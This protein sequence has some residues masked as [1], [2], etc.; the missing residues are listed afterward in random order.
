MSDAS[1]KPKKESLVAGSPADKRQ[2]AAKK[3]REERQKAYTRNKRQ[4]LI[5]KIVVL[6]IV[7]GALGGIGYGIYDKTKSSAEAAIPDGVKSY[8]YASGQHD[9]NFN[10]W[11]ENPPV[12]GIHNNTW[13]KCQFYSAPIMTGKGVHS[14][15]HGA[16]W[17][18]YSPDLPQD[19]IDKI[20]AVADGQ[21]FI[22]ASPYLG[23][24]APIVLSSWNHQLLLQSFDQKTVDQFIKVFKHSQ[25]YTPEYGANCATGDTSTVG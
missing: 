6:V 14:L 20:K 11:T 9:D 7:I 25:Q 21:D 13:Q 23:I 22:L 4:I 5:T 15:E 12:G 1:R 8:T 17:I 2:D 18:T 16:V 24:P 3:R 19:Q 10:A